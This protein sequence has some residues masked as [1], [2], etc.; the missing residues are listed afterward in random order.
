MLTIS[1][2]T[3]GGRRTNS[4]RSL[5]HTWFY[6]SLIWGMSPHEAAAFVHTKACLTILHAICPQV[7]RQKAYCRKATQTQEGKMWT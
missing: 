7:A 5:L 6:L 2:S 1:E 4:C 3:F